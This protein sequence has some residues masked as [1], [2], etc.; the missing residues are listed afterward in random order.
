[1][2]QIHAPRL[3]V[4]YLVVGAVISLVSLTIVVLI[5]QYSID[6]VVAAGKPLSERN[7]ENNGTLFS[8]PVELAP[9]YRL[10]V[11]F[12]DVEVVDAE[13]GQILDAT[14]FIYN[15]ENQEDL[16]TVGD[17]SCEDFFIQ[18][19]ARI[20]S[21]HG[22]YLCSKQIC[23]VLLL[24]EIPLQNTGINLIVSYNLFGIFSKQEEIL[25]RWEM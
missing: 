19:A 24:K 12:Q 9:K 1:M 13:S 18:Y 6:E 25:V 16:Y 7:Q 20:H 17:I 14:V 15:L 21:P 5:G 10:P 8:L 23:V 11:I 4:L 3:K 22:Y 2:A